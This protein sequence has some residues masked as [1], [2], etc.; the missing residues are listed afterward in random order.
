MAGIEMKGFED[1]KRNVE[2]FSMVVQD[3][4][5]KAAED[6]AAQVVKT[7]VETAAPRNTGKLA[8]SVQVFESRDRKAL[9]GQTR[10]RLL[11]GPDKR[12]GFYG[13]L[14]QKGW[15]WSKGRRK[16]TATGTTHSQSG[17]TEGSHRIP[18]QQWFP[19]SA[20]IEAKARAAGEAAFMAVV[21]AE[22]R[23]MS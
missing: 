3:E 7:T 18:P 9:T 6:A 11:I 4:A 21:E 23:R 17:P 20:A 19:D 8:S 14:L 1:L 5:I 10:R 15:I 22:F 12:K 16:R 13:F 2:Q